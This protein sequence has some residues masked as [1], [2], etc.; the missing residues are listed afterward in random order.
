[1][2]KASYFAQLLRP[3][4][5]QAIAKGVGLPSALVVRHTSQNFASLTY[6]D[7]KTLRGQRVSN[8]RQRR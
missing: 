8:M 3:F 5:F 1:M 2:P 4:P 7:Q 6:I